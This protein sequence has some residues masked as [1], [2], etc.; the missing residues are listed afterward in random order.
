MAKN[1]GLFNYGMLIEAFHI[2]C[3][4]FYQNFMKN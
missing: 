2:N 3:A 4:K 1:Y